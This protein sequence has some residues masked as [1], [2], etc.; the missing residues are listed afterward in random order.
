MR[1]YCI[2]VICFANNLLSAAESVLCRNVNPSGRDR[3]TKGCIADWAV[4]GCRMRVENV[5]GPVIAGGPADI[6]KQTR[7][8]QAQKL[9]IR[10]NL[11]QLEVERWNVCIN[12]GR[13]F[14]RP[15]F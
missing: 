12:K 13:L 1:S 14:S 6:A 5:C 10:R 15:L 3:S 9:G 8:F 2:Y 4:K 11:S 7:N